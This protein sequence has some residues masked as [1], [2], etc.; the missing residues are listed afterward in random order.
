MSADQYN[1]ND[2]GRFT[3]FVTGHKYIPS[4]SEVPVD[5]DAYDMLEN[6]KP[7]FYV[8]MVERMHEVLERHKNHVSNDDCGCEDDCDCADTEVPGYFVWRGNRKP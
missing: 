5:S 8:H 4:P 6:G 1:R 2:D 3:G 7:G